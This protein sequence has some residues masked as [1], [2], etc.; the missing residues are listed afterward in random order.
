MSMHIEF[1]GS[2]TDFRKASVSLTED[3]DELND[4]MAHFFCNL[5][6]FYEKKY[7]ISS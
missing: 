3:Y 7:T 2:L 6:V 4:I 5:I 1:A